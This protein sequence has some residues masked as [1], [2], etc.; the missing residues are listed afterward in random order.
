MHT[1]G[2]SHSARSYDE[3]LEMNR[4]KQLLAN[5]RTPIVLGALA[6]LGN[7]IGTTLSLFG[8]ET[9]GVLM[10]YVTWISLFAVA[11]WLWSS[12]SGQMH[13]AV[14][15]I[16]NFAKT[17]DTF[18]RARVTQYVAGDFAGGVASATSSSSSSSS[19][20]NN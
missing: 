15:E 3:A 4:H 14:A 8:L 5:M 9:I 12:F 18:V 19:K 13:T 10:G 20:K 17:V 2:S 7:I 11:F 1:P 16:D 6:F